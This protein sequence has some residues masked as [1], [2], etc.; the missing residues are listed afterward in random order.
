MIRQP[1]K[2]PAGGT[3]RLPVQVVLSANNQIEKLVYEL[4]NPPAGIELRE[5]TTTSPNRIDIE[6]TCDAAKVKAGDIGNLIITISGER[7]SAPDSKAA[8]NRQRIQLGAVAAVP[9]QIVAR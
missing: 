8:V 7:K 4:S 5:T 1:L 2:I 9:Y 6:L 3:V